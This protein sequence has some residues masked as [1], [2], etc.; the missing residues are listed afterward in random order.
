[1]AHNM[2][3]HSNLTWEQS[4]YF[5]KQKGEGICISC[6]KLCSVVDHDVSHYVL[7]GNILDKNYQS[8]KPYDSLH[9]CVGCVVKLQ[10]NSISGSVEGYI[11][12]TYD[13]IKFHVDGCMKDEA[14]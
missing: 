2:I 10:H 13:D 14:P 6:N 4:Q 3:F 7:Y 5:I 8:D 11:I 9:I 12:V 1:M